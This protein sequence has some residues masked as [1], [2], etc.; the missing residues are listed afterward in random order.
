MSVL[1]PRSALTSALA[2]ALTVALAAGVLATAEAPARAAI[3]VSGPGDAV[4][5]LSTNHVVDEFGLV[6][7]MGEAQNS[8]GRTLESVRVVIDQ[9]DV[10]GNVLD[11]TVAPVLAARLDGG[12]KSAFKAYLAPVPGASRWAVRRALGDPAISPANHRFTFAI[13]GNYTDEFGFPHIVGTVRNDNTGPA[14]MVGVNATF[15]DLAGKVVDAEWTVAES[16]EF[17]RMA[18]GETGTFDVARMDGPSHSSVVLTGDAGNDPAPLPTVWSAVSGGGTAKNSQASV[19]MGGRLVKRGTDTGVPGAVIALLRDDINSQWEKVGDGVT[20]DNGVVNF[21]LG[22]LYNSTYRLSLLASPAHEPAQSGT[23]RL[24]VNASLAVDRTQVKLFPGNALFIKATLQ[25]PP[26]GQ[27]VTLQR[28]AGGAW[29]PL[30][31]AKLTGD[32]YR[33][34]IKGHQQKKGQT[35]YRVV[36]AA[37]SWYGAGTS[38]VVNVTVR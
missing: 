6:A 32:S 15:F 5:V 19:P 9:Y 34:R 21:K 29:K 22:N 18:P 11:T 4:Q 8:S 24:V 25:Y 30:V 7:V 1:I 2:S 38:P 26:P 10:A 20:D 33:F 3:S 27:S 37:S 31:S 17:L 28:W 23:V 35:K 12:E 36:S 16:S 14:T 13:T